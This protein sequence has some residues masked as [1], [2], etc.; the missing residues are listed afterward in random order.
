MLYSII[1]LTPV[2]IMRFR[3]TG[4]RIIIHITRQRRPRHRLSLCAANTI[5]VALSES[6]RAICA[7]MVTSVTTT[8]I[9]AAA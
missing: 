9:A 3:D 8:Q 6:H 7:G 2:L 1:S 5:A 4:G